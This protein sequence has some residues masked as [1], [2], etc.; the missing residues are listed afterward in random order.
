M[1]PG[2]DCSQ[3]LPRE[4]FG[5]IHLDQ[6]LLIAPAGAIRNNSFGPIA[7]NRSCWSNSAKL[8]RNN[9]SHRS[10]SARCD[11]LLHF[12]GINLQQIGTIRRTANDCCT[13]T[14]STCN[15]SAQLGALRLIGALLRD[16]SATIPHNSARCDGLQLALSPD[17][18][19]TIRCIS[20]RMDGLVPFRWTNQ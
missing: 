20:A 15:N 17:K 12:R 1:T 6:L 3:L 13:F 2:G 16:Q 10:N 7:P 4:R 11:G 9:C 14:S 18:S 19:A 8:A 5:A